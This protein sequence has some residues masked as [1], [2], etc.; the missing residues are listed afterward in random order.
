MQPRQRQTAHAH[1]RHR[2]IGDVDELDAL[3]LQIRG[4]IEDLLRVQPLRR[5]KLHADDEAPGLQRAPQPRAA[6]G[7]LFHFGSGTS[8]ADPPR[9]AA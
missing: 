4:A 7:G 8:G 3:A 9:L 5:V 1:A 6:G 2:A